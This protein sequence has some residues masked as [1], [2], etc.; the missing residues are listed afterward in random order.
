MNS[1]FQFLICY[2]NK[3]LILIPFLFIFFSCS[4]K[5]PEQKKNSL[6]IHNEVEINFLIYM[7][8]DNNLE[9][10]G[11]QNIRELQEIGSS[12]KCNI[13]V[14]FDR[15]E[16]YDRTEDNWTNTKLFLI[17]KN[18][19]TMNDDCIYDFEEL[20]M[21]SV[22]SLY[23]F[24]ELVNTYFPAKNTIL[25]LWSH[26]RGV[27]PDGIISRSIIEDYTTGYGSTMMMSINDLANC[28]KKFEDISKKKI[29]II[30]F[31]A[32]YMQMIEIC[33][34]L[35][36]LTDYILGA[37]TSIPGIGSNY[38]K[39]ANFLTNNDFSIREL[40]EFFLSATSLSSS[41]D[42][43]YS[44]IDTSQIDT[45]LYYFNN[46]CEELMNYSNYYEIIEKRINM[47]KVA[48]VYPEFTDLYEFISNFENIDG[49]NIL[50]QSLSRLIV[51]SNSI[52][53]F[54]DKTKGIGINFPYEES[55]ICFYKSED[56]NYEILDF[57]NDTY[58]DEFLL[59]VW[60]VLQ[61]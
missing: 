53:T 41:S 27:Y 36:D 34:Q 4:Y 5:I 56:T 55:E 15:S 20:D 25:D 30:F 37:E 13:L 1:C 45:F 28:I 52:G 35:K 16:G 19:K 26:G 33:Y 6:S 9:R 38:K 17:S 51:K 2:S 40:A 10:F 32:C 57:Y 61:R 48:T 29:D 42:Y 46:F 43:S 54:V 12:E 50:L 7:A 31:D 11:I 59:K 44:L 60:A 14:L 39:I 8:G 49:Q 58:F 3:N 23:N 47:T 18:P 22:D 21:T 24:L